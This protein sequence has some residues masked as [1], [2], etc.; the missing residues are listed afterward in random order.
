MPAKRLTQ[1]H[2]NYLGGYRGLQGIGRR[3]II[4]AVGKVEP[5][6]RHAN[7]DGAEVWGGDLVR[8]GEARGGQLPSIVGSVV[9]HGQRPAPDGDNGAPVRIVPL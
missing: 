2:L 6:L 9:R 3:R 5:S 1:L 7:Q 8:R 4:F